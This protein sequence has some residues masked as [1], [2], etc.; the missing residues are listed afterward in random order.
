M[1]DETFDA[2][3]EL[4]TAVDEYV[5]ADGRRNLEGDIS[6]DEWNMA[7]FRFETASDR[8]RRVVRGHSGRELTVRG[9]GNL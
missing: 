5:I 9:L 2:L 4:S 8:A 7:V 6:M 3:R 1:T